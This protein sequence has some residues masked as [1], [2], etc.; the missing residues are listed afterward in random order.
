M[1]TPLFYFYLSD[2]DDDFENKSSTF[3]QW[4][5]LS[6]AVVNPKVSLVDLRNK[7]KRRGASEFNIAMMNSGKHS[8]QLT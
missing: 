5:V 2:M 7:G 6:G 4:L 3:V 1:S 8:N